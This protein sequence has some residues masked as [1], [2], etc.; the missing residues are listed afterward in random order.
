MVKV[1]NMTG[2]SRFLLVAGVLALGVSSASASIWHRKAKAPQQAA[3]P[4]AAAMTLDAIEVTSTAT[5][6]IILR[7]SGAPAFTSLSPTPDQFIVDLSGTTKAAGLTVPSHLP[8]GVTSIRAEEVTEMGSKLTRVTVKLSQTGTPQASA[9]GNSVVVA[10]PAA[11]PATV[12]VAEAPAP[13]P[14]TTEPVVEAPK[15]EPVA[16]SKP[17]PKAK[18]LKRI[19]MSGSDVVIATDG[20]A[21]YSAF[22]LAN[23]ARIKD[24]TAKHALDVNDPVVKRVRAGQFKPDVAR[25]VIDLAEATPYNIV[26]N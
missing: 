25:V 9:D 18:S 19:D 14:V 20:N 16:D 13:A 26:K 3:A 10:M 12:A 6:Q 15:P 22:K 1:G 4:T 11:A 24:K 21:S 7:T 2:A 17:L 5:P 8:S 23:P